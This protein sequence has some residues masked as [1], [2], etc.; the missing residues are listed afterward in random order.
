MDRAPDVTERA[1]A[2]PDGESHQIKPPHIL[3]WERRNSAARAAMRLYQEQQAHPLALYR[4]G[5][6]PDGRW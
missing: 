6:D 1:G 2:G 5:A 4:T 3:A